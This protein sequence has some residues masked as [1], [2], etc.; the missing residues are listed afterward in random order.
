M[1]NFQHLWD[2]EPAPYNHWVPA[3]GLFA[4]AYAS[5]AMGAN[6]KMGEKLSA[7]DK[8]SGPPHFHYSASYDPI[9]K[10]EYLIRKGVDTE[11]LASIHAPQGK[12]IEA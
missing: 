7:M 2:F 11:E 4:T 10:N 3:H 1:S 9:D 6:S 5:W 8:N 12:L